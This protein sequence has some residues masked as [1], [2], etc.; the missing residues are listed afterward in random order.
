LIDLLFLYYM[1]INIYSE[2][3]LPRCSAQ[4]YLVKGVVSYRL[5]VSL[6]VAGPYWSS[7]IA[8]VVREHSV[9]SMIY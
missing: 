8:E 6:L 4:S 9:S 5:W 2:T 1:M 3:A 7:S